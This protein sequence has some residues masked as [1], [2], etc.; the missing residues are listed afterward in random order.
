MNKVKEMAGDIVIL[1]ITAVAWTVFL[2]FRR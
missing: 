2:I 1:A